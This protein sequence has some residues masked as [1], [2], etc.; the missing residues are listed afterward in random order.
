MN[1]CSLLN[2]GEKLAPAAFGVIRAIGSS[3]KV[4]RT[5]AFLFATS[6]S[7]RAESTRIVK[8]SGLPSSACVSGWVGRPSRKSAVVGRMRTDTSPTR[9]P[10]ASTMGSHWVDS[11]V[12]ASGSRYMYERPTMPGS[13]GDQ[14]GSSLVWRSIFSWRRIH[15][16][17]ALRMPRQ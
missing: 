3:P 12:C 13:G 2:C 15:A 6:I 4:Y 1:F 9:L 11:Q 17:Y 14:N 7:P 8:W 16:W 10:W 5:Y